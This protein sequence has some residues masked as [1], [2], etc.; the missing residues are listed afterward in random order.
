MEKRGSVTILVLIVSTLAIIVLASLI[1]AVAV[2]IKGWQ[3]QETNQKALNIAEAGVNY[4]RWH[5]AH[6]PSDFQDGTGAQGPYL[7][8]Y[9]DPQ[10]VKIGQ[11]SLDIVPPEDGSSVV[12]ISSTG[13]SLD[14]DNIKRTIS[15]SY[16]K[17]SFAQYSFLHN[18]NVW[19]GSG[20]TVNGVIH[21]NGGI[22]MDG[23]N[24]S[25]VT[26][27]KETYT[28][29]SETGCSPS[30][31]KPG[32]WGT[33]EGSDLWEFPTAPVDFNSVSVDFV[34]AKQE[35]QE[36]GIYL[37]PSSGYGYHLQFNTDGTV[38]VY[39][40]TMMRS[41]KGWSPD[42]G[43]ENLYQEIRRENNLGTYNL[44]QN[45]IIFV[46]DTTW[47]DGI[48]NGKATIIAASFPVDTSSEVIWITDNITYK[49]KDG[50]SSLGL[51]AQKDIYY[52]LNIPDN[53]QI[54]AAL[55]AQKGKIIRH[56]YSYW[57]V[58]SYYSD[59]LKDNLKIYGSVI[60]NQKSY[61]NY[62]NP[63]WSGF[64]TRQI[65]Y[66]PNLM[67][68]PPPYFPTTGEYEFILWEEN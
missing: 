28:C 10:G 4:Y 47:V 27:T 53:F 26:S 39:E 12:T 22:R 31:E 24:L 18:A 67:Y 44:S 30:Q 43:C 55:M 2:H 50:S 42:N 16:G 9:F 14:E 54:D 60:S 64:T 20:L 17:P 35:A 8:D 38:S 48:V 6:A 5:L 29:G 3:R 51:I 23:E 56:F 45:N 7:H 1:S 34:L 36:K 52:G 19:F 66:D 15:T 68:S 58:C 11:F 40:I 41:K 21:S 32:V 63:A 57:W 13:W 33:G 46:E 65:I 62:G 61:W 59:A 49:E 25:L 37:A